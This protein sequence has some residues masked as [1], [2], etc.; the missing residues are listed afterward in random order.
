MKKPSQ[1]SAEISETLRREIF[2]KLEKLQENYIDLLNHT[3]R[4]VHKSEEIVFLIEKNPEVVAMK[5]RS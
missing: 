3:F 2:P 5:V 1:R 4:I